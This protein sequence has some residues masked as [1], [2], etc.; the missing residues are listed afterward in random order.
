MLDFYFW[1]GNLGKIIV[2]KMLLIVFFIV[3]S[4]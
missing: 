1:Y 2:S 4:N 3:S